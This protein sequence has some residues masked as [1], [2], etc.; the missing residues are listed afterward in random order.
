MVQVN[1]EGFPQKSMDPQR[2]MN[3]V[4]NQAFDI[5]EKQMTDGTVAP[6]V[7]TFLMRMGT[8]RDGLETENLRTKSELNKSRIKEIDEKASQKSMM[9]EAVNAFKSYQPDD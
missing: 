6:S 5:V 1:K 3:Q 2:R 7:L 8:D 9:E 4:V